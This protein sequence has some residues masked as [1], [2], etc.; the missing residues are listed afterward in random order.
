MLNCPSPLH[1]QIITPDDEDI[2]GVEPVPKRIKMNGMGE[3][4]SPSKK[5]R[6]EK[7]GLVLLNGADNRMADDVIEID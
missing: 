6:L 7:D 5:R 2:I 3:V 1:Q 4:T